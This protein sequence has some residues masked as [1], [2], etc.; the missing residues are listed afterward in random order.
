MNG[1]PQGIAFLR[2]ID[3]RLL[4]LKTVNDAM[5]MRYWDFGV[6]YRPGL[7]DDQAKLIN[8]FAPNDVKKALEQICTSAAT[9]YYQTFRVCP[10]VKVSL[11]ALSNYC[12]NIMATVCMN[13]KEP[14]VSVSTACDIKNPRN[15]GPLEK[16]MTIFER[17]SPFRST[18][19]PD[20]F[21]SGIL[22][23]TMQPVEEEGGSLVRQLF[24]EVW[25]FDAVPL[26][27]S[28]TVSKTVKAPDNVGR[29][30]ITSSFWS[31]GQRYSVCFSETS[32]KV[33]ADLGS[34]GQLGQPSYSRVALSP[35]RPT[36]TKILTL[37][38]LSTGS[39]SVTFVL[40]QSLQQLQR[41]AVQWLPYPFLASHTLI[42]NKR[43]VSKKTERDEAE[44]IYKR[45]VLDAD[46]PLFSDSLEKSSHD[47]SMPRDIFKFLP[48]QPADVPLRRAR[49]DTEYRNSF[50]SDIIKSL[51]VDL[52]QFK[53]M[54]MLQQV[55]RQTIETL[56]DRIGSLI[57]D[58]LRFSDCENQSACGYSEY[59]SP[60]K[61]KERSIALTAIATSLLCEASASARTVCGGITFLIQSLLKNWQEESTD[62]DGLI[63]LGHPTDKEWFLKA[64]I[65]QVSRDCA[66]YQCLRNDE[67]WYN[68]VSSFYSLDE[69]WKWDI[70][71]LA[72][73]AYMG[74]N[75]T[76]E[77]MRIKL[78]TMSNA[79]PDWCAGLGQSA[80][81]WL[82]VR[83]LHRSGDVL[84]NALG[85]LAFVSPG[86]E[87]RSM[88]WDPLAIWLYEQQLQD[89]TFE[90][91]ILP[92][93]IRNLTMETKGHGKANV[94]LRILAR[95]RQRSRRGL[96][97]DDYYPVRITV[98]QEGV[99]PGTL[100]Q[101]V[102]LK[103]LSP[104]VTT[105]EITHGLYTGFSTSLDNIAIL[106]NSSSLSFV[107]LPTVSTFATHFVLEGFRRGEPLC[108]IL[109]AT[110]PR[111]N[112]EPLHLAPVAIA[113]RH[114]VEGL[115]G[116]A[117]IS[118][119]DLDY[120]PS[121]TRRQASQLL[122][123][124]PNYFLKRARRGMLDD[125]IDTVCFQGGACSCAESSCGVKCG[126]CA[127]DTMADLE[128]LMSKENTF[129]A[130][131][132]VIDSQKVLVGNSFYTHLST[133][134]REKSGPAKVQI[135]DKLDIWLRDCNPRCQA[136]TPAKQDRFFIIGEAGALTLDTSGR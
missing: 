11:S 36:D 16:A 44:E 98:L 21:S 31:P 80:R 93:N 2:G 101:T 18:H 59:S 53:R 63:D 114:P 116:L 94:G 135:S 133:D 113:A 123:E 96:T 132:R 126:L 81:D 7:R 54:K 86:A 106:P 24:H 47:T 108:Y 107:T 121:R 50:L 28:G 89:G 71:C 129:G 90:N 42:T 20:D 64:L 136:T 9:H 97:P 58:M 105:M 73:L 27:A 65:L 49:R 76:S 43:Y 29:W 56:E 57:S 87:R 122:R 60:H 52:Y 41:T 104:I 85:I 125:S 34:F 110:E 69:G 25:L 70:R 112:Y 51:S 103:T 134:V 33:C 128:A 13:S 99:T 118:H 40:R 88:D 95:K 82:V 30:A 62:L 83:D 100:H 45:I 120:R 8:L 5:G 75:A 55:D 74:T 102:C 38:F 130:L 17:I 1:E 84:V 119:P 109:G 111:H 10:E 12:I 26:G 72:A 68:L 61:P 78:A 117:L 92:T 39:T 14:K 35:S 91:A 67:A 131:L 46:K 124:P 6:L 3:D 19:S 77:I 79:Y 32:R 115:I 48:L 127:K 23:D 4:A 37:K 15:C 22:S 66:A